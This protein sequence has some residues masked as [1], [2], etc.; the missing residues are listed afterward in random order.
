MHIGDIG[1]NGVISLGFDVVGERNSPSCR[2][3]RECELPWLPGKQ[4]F[5]EKNARKNGELLAVFRRVD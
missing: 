4:Y 2:I 5:Y 3:E 1:E